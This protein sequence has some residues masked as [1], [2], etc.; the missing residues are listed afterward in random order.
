MLVALV[1]AL[2]I[3]FS[4]NSVVFAEDSGYYNEVYRNQF[5]FSPEANWMNDPNGMV[6]YDGE[7]HLF[8]Q[9]YPYGKT[10]GPMHWGH[11]VSTDLVHWKHP[12]IALSPDENGWIFSGS[13]VIDW[14]N[15]AGFGKEAMVAIFT[16]ADGPKQVQSI[17]YSLDKGRTW[18]KYE[19]NPVMPNPP[20][21]DW[22]DPKVFWHEETKQ[23]V[24]A[25]A[26]RN[27]V[28]FYT[29]HDLKNW[30]HASDFGPD[31]GIQGNGIPG[32]Y[33]YAL[34]KQKGSSFIY[35]ADITLVEKNGHKGAGGLVFRS[36]QEVR[37]AY[38][39]TV[40]A[41]KNT[42]SLSKMADG[43]LHE[44]AASS[45]KLEAG[46]TYHLKVVTDYE[47]LK[48]FLDDKLVI[49]ETDS[50]FINGQFGL[51]AR[52]STAVFR[53]VKVE[54]SSN[55]EPKEDDPISPSGTIKDFSAVVGEWV[56]S[57]YGIYGG[58]WECPSLIQLPVDGDPNKKKWVL[59]VSIND[60]AV[61]GGS[62]MQYFV[63]QFDGKTFKSDNTPQTVLWADYGADFYAG[64]EWSNLEGENG[65]KFWLG[66]MSNWS[67]ANN[68][69][70][71]PWRSSMS[72]PRKLELTETADGLRL[73]QTPVS[74]KKI[75]DHKEKIKHEDVVLS[76]DSSFL[77]NLT[78]DTFEIIAEFDVSKATA[79]E[80]GVKVRKGKHGDTDEQTVIGYD[81]AEQ[82]LFV[83]RINSGNFNFGSNV[84]G[85]HEA[86]LR[87]SHKTV[88]MHIFLD[89]SAVEVFGGD[90]E[91][92]ITDQIFPLSSSDGLELYS[93][94]GEATLK[95]LEIYPLKSIWGKS[96]V[97]SQLTG[98]TTINGSWGDTI[99]G[100]QGQSTGDAFTIAKNTGNDFTYQA[101]IKVLD[102]DSHPDDPN[103][104]T[105]DNPVGA[106]AL[107]F[108]SDATGSN[109]YVANVDVLNNVVK[110]IKFADGKP[111]ELA[112]YNDNG[113][114]DL[115]PN[116]DYQLKVETNGKNIKVYLNGDL[117]VHTRDKS[118]ISG[119]FGLNVWNSTAVFNNIRYTT[120][121]AAN[122][123]DTA[124]YP[125]VIP[126]D[127]NR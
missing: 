61:A 85:K 56:P 36:D 68:T 13:A 54:N 106:G 37:N 65:E 18:K 30:K 5:H 28:M 46:Q 20:I 67:Y 72:L 112:V 123:K 122:E 40:D 44:M 113:N 51:V 62:G 4:V 77:P 127:G 109:A 79:T 80:F 103:K 117:V 3:I 92:V 39:T 89:R 82:K 105:V 99:A 75:R 58:I 125:R 52:N 60:G 55:G 118:F 27:K 53:N 91:S 38:L 114:L 81:L 63:G 71:S 121:Q 19:G 8:Y 50:S 12:P 16:H 76:K 29:S 73:K 2:T 9:Y 25:L 1:L 57:T 115:K 94:G 98:W 70:T 49:H 64:V 17:A 100:R 10:W 88:K 102:T 116:T 24:M 119:H 45:A 108:R 97:K 120:K 35:E 104:D 14:N 26:A 107:V 34:S 41:E 95:S 43:K 7:Y 74:L 110:L 101:D 124:A 31:G 83:D 15:T 23:W 84:K 87:S 86:P 22:R 96:P 93:K 90:G 69:P 48:V 66:W 6:Y 59:L 21:N 33:S 111:T 126:A 47:N 32:S 42:V 78:G 11:A